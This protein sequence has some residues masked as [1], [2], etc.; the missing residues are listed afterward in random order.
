MGDDIIYVNVEDGLN[1]VLKNTKLYSNL[2]AKFKNYTQVEEIEAAFAENDMEKACNSAHTLKGLAANLSLTEL[3][4]QVVE[5][6]L[7]LKAGQKNADQLALIKK[8]FA[9]T[10]IEVDKV[11]AQYA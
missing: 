9:Q 8:V 4:K 2:L 11:I 5:L 1:R 3:F 6:E 7:Q 10:I